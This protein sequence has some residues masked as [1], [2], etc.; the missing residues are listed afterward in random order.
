MRAIASRGT[1]RVAERPR[2][3]GRAREPGSATRARASVG[4]RPGPPQADTRAAE[5]GS[6]RRPGRP[7]R[8]GPEMERRFF[9]AIR[10]GAT[11]KVA[12]GYAGISE[13]T[14]YRWLGDERSPYQEFR[15]RLLKEE[16]TVQVEIVENL[17]AA[18]RTRPSFGLKFLARR[19]PEEWGPVKSGCTC[20]CSC[21]GRPSTTSAAEQGPVAAPRQMVTFRPEEGSPLAELL[22][23]RRAEAL[24]SPT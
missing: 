1:N 8:H 4:A 10:R 2:A 16:A 17:V 9:E 15:E 13:G 19:W 7:T 18:C 11:R 3:A 21:C 6:A 20:G 5:R 24:V 14:L 22:A 12:A 23:R